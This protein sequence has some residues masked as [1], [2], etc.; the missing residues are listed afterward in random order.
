MKAIK[1]VFAISTSHCVL[2]MMI[3]QTSPMMMELLRRSIQLR[4]AKAM[5]GRC[6][7]RRQANRRQDLS[8]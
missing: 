2:R 6:M 4:N 8:T 3:L 7:L 5:Q 1:R